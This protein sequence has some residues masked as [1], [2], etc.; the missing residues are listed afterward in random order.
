MIRGRFGDTTTSPYVEASVYLPRLNI[1]GY[2]SFLV[3]TGASGSVLMPPDSKKLGV[4]F[5]RLINPMKSH[6]IGGFSDGFNEIA[7]L[8]F[9]DGHHV[10]GFEIELEIAEPTRDNKDLPSLLGRDMLNRCRVVADYK[11]NTLTFTPHTWDL[12]IKL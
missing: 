7:V 11:N 6:G 9:S 10:Y 3:D 8:G 5:S 1:R 12:R 4:R 2:V